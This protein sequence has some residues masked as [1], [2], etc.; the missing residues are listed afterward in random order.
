[1]SCEVKIMHCAYNTTASHRTKRLLDSRSR[2]ISM[3]LSNLSHQIIYLKFQQQP[4]FF[5]WKIKDSWWEM[6]IIICH[7]NHNLLDKLPHIISDNLSMFFYFLFFIYEYDSS[8]FGSVYSLIFNIHLFL[9]KD[10]S[11][12][13]FFVFLLIRNILEKYFFFG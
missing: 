11:Y 5:F 1:M 2:I 8:M 9:W 3:Y 7:M 6:M 12:S 10:R 13:R 4:F